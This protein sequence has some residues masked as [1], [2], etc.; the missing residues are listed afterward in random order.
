MDFLKRNYVFARVHNGEVEI[1]ENVKDN[2][3]GT[4]S[5]DSDKFSTYA[6]AYTDVVDTSN[7]KTGDNIVLYITLLAL[8]V[9]GFVGVLIYKKKK[10]YN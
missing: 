1:I 7:P 2:G 5:G 8:S 3:D 10:Q 6:V 4:L 9:V